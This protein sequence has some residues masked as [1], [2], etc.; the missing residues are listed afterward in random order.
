MHTS[1]Q[2]KRECGV[3][4][5]L[6][7]SV[8][9]ALLRHM[10]LCIGCNHSGLWSKNGCRQGHGLSVIDH[11]FEHSVKST[12]SGLS[13]YGQVLYMW[14]GHMQASGKAASRCKTDVAPCKLAHT[15]GRKP[16]SCKLHV[17]ARYKAHRRPSCGGHAHACNSVHLTQGCF[18]TAGLHG[19]SS[20]LVCFAHIMQLSVAAH[21]CNQALSLIH[22]STPLR[23]LM[24]FTPLCPDP[25]S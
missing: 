18:T 13:R 3:L 17:S 20:A 12:A 6:L 22:L 1:S 23:G 7:C 16:G 15:K 2:P 24:C 10:H 9:Y 8:Q 4:C 5:R 19:C 14:N 11:V 25:S 21:K